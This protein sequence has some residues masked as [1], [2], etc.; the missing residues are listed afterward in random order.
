MI[1][2]AF[3]GRLLS[4]I[5]TI[6]RIDNSAVVHEG[7]ENILH[8]NTKCHRPHSQISTPLNDHDHQPTQKSDLIK[9]LHLL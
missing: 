8:V 5:T 2:L 4:V 9:T 6:S 1:Q 3:D 7:G